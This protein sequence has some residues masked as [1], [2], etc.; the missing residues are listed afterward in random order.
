MCLMQTDLPGAGRAEDHRDL[1]LRQRHVQPAQ[2]VVAPERLVHVDELDRVGLLGRADRAACGRRTR[3]PRPAG[4][5]RARPAVRSCSSPAA[6]PGGRCRRAKPASSTSPPSSS[7]ANAGSPPARGR[8]CGRSCGRRAASARRPPAPRRGP[9][10][11][12]RW[13]PSRPSSPRRRPAP[14]RRPAHSPPGPP[15]AAPPD[16]APRGFRASRPRPPSAQPPIGARGFAPQKIC[17]PSIPMTCTSTR[18]STIDFA[19]ARPT[20]TGPPLAL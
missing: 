9:G 14:A 15:A 17:V 16:A 6:S 3:R 1:V 8:G 20:P 13:P 19:V 5:V 12:R 11:G 7:G 10:R 18:F 4:R 2:H